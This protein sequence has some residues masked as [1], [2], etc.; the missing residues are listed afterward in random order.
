VLKQ[1]YQLAGAAQEP[2]GKLFPSINPETMA[3]LTELLSIGMNTDMLKQ[4]LVEVLQNRSSRI[5]TTSRFPFEEERFQL[6]RRRMVERNEKS[7]YKF[8]KIKREMP[9]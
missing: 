4:R 2:R 6:N 1:F 7:L 5:I 3:S 9:L 8:D